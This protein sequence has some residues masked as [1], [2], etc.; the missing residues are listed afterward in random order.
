MLS[1]VEEVGDTAS[2]DDSCFFEIFGR[3][4]DCAVA[5]AN[6]LD[7]P[8]LPFFCLPLLCF[9]FFGAS[10]LMGDPRKGLDDEAAFL[11]M[12]EDE[13]D[14]PRK[15][16]LEVMPDGSTGRDEGIRGWRLGEE[17]AIA[18]LDSNAS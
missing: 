14:S 11:R 3:D 4:G 5:E 13:D 7:P 18:L 12:E 17:S 10:S 16:L 2:D 8:C 6:A 9:V 1:D 15:T